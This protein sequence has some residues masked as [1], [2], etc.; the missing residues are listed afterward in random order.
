M[1][2]SHRFK[3]NEIEKELDGNFRL[4]LANRIG[5]FWSW[6]DDVESRYSGFYHR[7]NDKLFKSIESIKLHD[8]S[9]IKKIQNNFWNFELERENGIKESFFI[10]YGFDALVYET[11]REVS[12]DLILDCKEMFDNSEWGR[13]YSFFEEDK[14][15]II[16]YSKSE[17][18]A[19]KYGF[20]LVIYSD[21]FKYRVKKDWILKDYKYDFK[22][23]DPPFSRYLF[24]A[25]ELEGSKFVFAV[26]KDKAK[27]IEEAKTAFENLKELKRDHQK[28]A[29]EF[30]SKNSAEISDECVNM[31]YLAAQF[32]LSNML[33]YNISGN[34]SGLYA[35]IPW[36]SQFWARDS[37]VSLAALPKKSKLGLFL[38]YLEEFKNNGKISSCGAGCMRGADVHGLFFKRAVELMEEN[39]LT[40]DEIFEI[41]NILVKEIND[42]LKSSTKDDF[43]VNG[44]KETWMDTDFKGDSRDGI[45]IEIQSLRLNMY[46]LAA[47]LTG[48]RRYFELEHNLSKKVRERFFNGDSLKDGIDDNEVRPNIFLAFYFYPELLFKHE[49][50]KVFSHALDHLWLSWG[51]L[52]SISKKSPL[53]CG[54]YRGCQEPNQSYHRGDSWY[55]MN[56]LAMLALKKV[57]MHRFKKKIEKILE[58]STEEILWS[59]ML[60]H[61]AEISSADKFG[62]NGCFAQSWSA[63]L[64]IEAIE[65][66]RAK[67]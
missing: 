15:V 27:A 40:Q 58:A 42:I 37:L 20:F 53:F 60:G 43:A 4:L 49:W 46:N 26:S 12:F 2:V 38:N 66:F 62:S 14:K 50:E 44:P 23:K 61:H 7:H 10:P 54:E 52:L 56:D 17:N 3:K 8:S 55:F 35:G 19:K 25:L 28:S 34:I 29:V 33:V 36:F 1:I 47:K 18:G 65:A 16:E 24:S 31:A 6:Q 67:N 64:Y 11:S 9:P 5:G 30:E 57:D 22:R 63:A 59:G 39:L 13:N 32:S 41:K 51:G 45:R 21:N 48:E